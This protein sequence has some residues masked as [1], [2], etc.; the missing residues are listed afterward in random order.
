M[1]CLNMRYF[2]AQQIV[3]DHRMEEHTIDMTLH[4][5]DEVALEG[6]MRDSTLWNLQQRWCKEDMQEGVVES[7]LPNCS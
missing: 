4:D 2:N 5:D 7:T 1:G 3:L 6:D